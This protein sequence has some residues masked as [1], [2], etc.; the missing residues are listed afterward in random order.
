MMDRQQFVGNVARLD[1]VH[2]EHPFLHEGKKIVLVP[3]VVEDLS[4]SCCGLE[5]CPPFLL[6]ED[7]VLDV[8]MPRRAGRIVGLIIDENQD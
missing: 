8:Q 1:F 6:N 5:I 2:R 7:D 4:D 3:L